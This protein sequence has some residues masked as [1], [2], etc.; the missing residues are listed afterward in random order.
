VFSIVFEIPFFVFERLGHKV[1]MLSRIDTLL[2]KFVLEDR[3]IKNATDFY[4]EDGVITMDFSRAR[5]VLSAER[6]KAIRFLK[7]AVSEMESAS[8]EPREPR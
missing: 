7:K 2:R 1:N 4:P 8:V 5:E 3:R 6:E